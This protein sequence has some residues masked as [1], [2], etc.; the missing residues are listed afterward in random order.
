MIR[1]AFIGFLLLLGACKQSENLPVS[2]TKGIE[3]TSG[4]SA[5]SLIPIQ[6]GSNTDL[7]FIQCVDTRDVRTLL[8]KAEAQ[9]I[10]GRLSL[11]NIP[12]IV[13]GCSLLKDSAAISWHQVSSLLSAAVDGSLASSELAFAQAVYLA[14]RGSDDG[15]DVFTVTPLLTAIIDIA[16]QQAS[17]I[18]DPI[19][20][21]NL[22]RILDGMFN[23][24]QSRSTKSVFSC[25]KISERFS[26]FQPGNEYLSYENLT[27]EIAKQSWKSSFGK[28]GN[29]LTGEIDLAGD[30]FKPDPLMISYN[31]D[32]M[33]FQ[34]V[35]GS[36]IGLSSKENVFVRNEKPDEFIVTEPNQPSIARAFYARE[37][38][39]SVVNFDHG[40]DRGADSGGQKLLQISNSPF[41]TSNLDGAERLRTELG[42]SVLIAPD[43]SRAQMV[44]QF[45]PSIVGY[46]RKAEHGGNSGPFRSQN[47][48]PK[49][50]DAD[51]Q[52]GRWSLKESEV[53]K[54][55]R[56]YIEAQKNAG[57]LVA[58]PEDA[59]QINQD[60]YESTKLGVPGPGPSKSKPVTF[61]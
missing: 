54:F 38:D 10:A 56:D 21:E 39:M 43:N 33:Q 24:C 28:K 19:G 16:N 40:R 12:A 50:Y 4:S 1:T 29:A 49:L 36:K 27:I 41:G 17:L 48:A 42:T 55:E 9:G 5:I 46:D 47:A 45:S 7:A 23:P 20:L 14:M 15:S 60:I 2:S 13:P 31:S 32:P 37:L 30:A 53:S 51:Y 8:W 25:K 18:P 57:K 61:E 6:N 52:N 22:F 11:E 26:N 3:N 34:K 35:N 58:K 59:R 44:V